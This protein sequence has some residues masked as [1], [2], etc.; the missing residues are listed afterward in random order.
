ML[1]DSFHIPRTVNLPANAK[2]VRVQSAK[3]SRRFWKSLQKAAEE[4]IKNRDGAISL[5]SSQELFFLH[6]DLIIKPFANVLMLSRTYVMYPFF[7][8][9]QQ[10]FDTAVKISVIRRSDSD[11]C[12]VTSKWMEINPGIIVIE[13][14]IR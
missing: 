4:R 6:K 12:E 7:N 14:R 10:K 9:G 5:I 3:L 13:I 8:E 2:S 11:Q 1:E